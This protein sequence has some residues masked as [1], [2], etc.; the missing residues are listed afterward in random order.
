MQIAIITTAF[1][2]GTSY[3]VKIPTP[4]FSD[5]RP[6]Q[7]FLAMPFFADSSYLRPVSRFWV[8]VALTVPS[9]AIAFTTYAVVTRRRRQTKGRHLAD[10]EGKDES[11]GG[12]REQGGSAMQ[13]ISTSGGMRLERLEGSRVSRV[14]DSG[15]R[16]VWKGEGEGKWSN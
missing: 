5:V 8:W 1:L 9:T 12:D 14:Y 6:S 7:A 13:E 4:P 16:F 10:L 2:P 15:A 11:A 3:A